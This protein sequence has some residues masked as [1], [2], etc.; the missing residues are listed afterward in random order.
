MHDGKSPSGQTVL[1]KDSFYFLFFTKNNISKRA[2]GTLY[3]Q[4]ING[5]LEWDFK[6]YQDVSF[7][8]YSSYNLFFLALFLLYPYL[9]PIFSCFY[10][11]LWPVISICS[12]YHMSV[13]SLLFFLFFSFLCQSVFNHAPFLVSS[14][15]FLHPDFFCHF[16]SVLSASFIFILFLPVLFFMQF[17]GFIQRLL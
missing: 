1:E 3:L 7:F 9:P 10:S 2:L 8:F 17:P 14:P 16:T 15:V 4:L 11:F 13:F 6:V 12:I 5:W